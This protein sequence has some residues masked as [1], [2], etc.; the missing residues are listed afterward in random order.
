MEQTGVEVGKTQMRVS[1]PP[2]R[3][4]EKPHGGRCPC[5]HC[6]WGAVV[7]TSRRLS[8]LFYEQRLTCTNP[9]CGHT[10]V[11][12]LIIERTIS[13]SAMPNP[14]IKLPIA[15]PRRRVD[16]TPAAANDE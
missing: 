14:A 4:R 12:S 3:I 16:G 13:P 2:R 9:D 8:P 11:A 7:R 6:A 1:E 10:F 15:P 5:P